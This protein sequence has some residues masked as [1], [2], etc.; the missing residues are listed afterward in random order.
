[1]ADITTIDQR[2]RKQ[3]RDDL[4][5]RI[6]QAKAGFESFDRSSRIEVPKQ[7][8]EGGTLDVF[9]LLQLVGQALFEAH[10]EREEEKAVKA[11]MDK[12]DSFQEQLDELREQVDQ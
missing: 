5:R 10:K 11:F 9:D 7:L 6:Q 2:I 4:S 8:M 12:V 3:A 1:M